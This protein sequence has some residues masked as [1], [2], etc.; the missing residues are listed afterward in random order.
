MAISFAHDLTPRWVRNTGRVLWHYRSLSNRSQRHAREEPSK[1]AVSTKA[2]GY[3]DLCWIARAVD[4]DVVSEKY[5]VHRL[6]RKAGAAGRLIDASEEH[7]Y[8]TRYFTNREKSI[9]GDS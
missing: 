7:K 8:R 6:F 3:R 2:D 1:N 5:L 9:P 4:G